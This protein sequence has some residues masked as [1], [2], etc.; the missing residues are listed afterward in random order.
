MGV[1]YKDYNKDYGEAE[2]GNDPE[3]LSWLACLPHS[4]QCMP[5]G[6]TSLLQSHGPYHGR[7]TPP[8]SPIKYLALS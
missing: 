8:P 5:P 7:D 3:K 2:V 6:S 4:N 1:N